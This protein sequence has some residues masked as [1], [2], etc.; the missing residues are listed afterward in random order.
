MVVGGTI[1]GE[2]ATNGCM[3]VVNDNKDAV[4]VD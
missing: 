3:L 4:V 1:Y 2:Y